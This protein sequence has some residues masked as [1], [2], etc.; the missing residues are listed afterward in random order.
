MFSLAFVKVIPGTFE[1]STCVACVL[2]DTPRAVTNTSPGCVTS[3]TRT[4]SIL[5]CPLTGTTIEIY[6][7]NEI[8]SESFLPALTEK[9]PSD[10]VSVPIVV[11]FTITFA[12]M[13]GLP[14]SVLTVPAIS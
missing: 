12:P 11:F 14:S 5:V 10:F 2:F 1:I 6:P 4:I 3:V 7:I 8:I 13:A 9:V